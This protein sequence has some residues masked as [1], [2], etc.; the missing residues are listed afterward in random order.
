[1]K[2][3]RGGQPTI[4][5]ITTG[6]PPA[7]SP[8]EDKNSD[9]EVITVIIDRSGTTIDKPNDAEIARSPATMHTVDAAKIIRPALMGP[10]LQQ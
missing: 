10:A 8:T 4:K 6:S 2:H 1:M 9:N 3:S 7:S 5:R